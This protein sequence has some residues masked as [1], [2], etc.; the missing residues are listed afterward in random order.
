MC[1]HYITL[2]YI[3]NRSLHTQAYS[4]FMKG[5]LYTN[6]N[7]PNP[8]KYSPN[9]ANTFKAQSIMGSPNMAISGVINPKPPKEHFKVFK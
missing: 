3:T 8:R 1:T 5:E 9:T 4:V 7:Y 6:S 2:H